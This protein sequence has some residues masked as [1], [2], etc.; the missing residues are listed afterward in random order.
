MLG[1]ITPAWAARTGLPPDVRVHAGLHDSNAAL[2]AARGFPEIGDDEATILS[3]GTWFVAMRSPG[4]D[5]PVDIA[6]LP[7]ARDCL[8]NVDVRGRLVPSARFM[9][10]REIEL[11]TGIDTRRVDIRP[12]QPALIAAVPGVAGGDGDGA[13]VDGAGG[14]ALPGACRAGGS[15]EPDDPH[16]RRAAACLYAALVVDTML[17]LIG[18]RERLLIEGRFAEAQVFVRALAVAAA[19]HRGLH[20]GRA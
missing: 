16:A 7:E 9:G 19:G 20:R 18:T 10:G 4:S 3:T 5:A 15:S 6:S 2:H 1:S 17:D 8:V 12:D 13:A 11:L 14:R